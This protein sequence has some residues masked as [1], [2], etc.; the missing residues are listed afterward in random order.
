MA[1]VKMFFA[2][3]TPPYHAST[4]PAGLAPGTNANTMMTTRSDRRIA[5]RKGSGIRRST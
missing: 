1:K 2:P 4:T 5:N 3:Q